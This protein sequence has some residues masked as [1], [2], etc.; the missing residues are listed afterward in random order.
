MKAKKFPVTQ[1]TISNKLGRPIDSI[2]RM[3]NLKSFYIQP[4]LCL[5]TFNDFFKSIPWEITSPLP[6]NSL[7]TVGIVLKVNLKGLRFF[8]EKESNNVPVNYFFNKDFET[9]TIH[10][11]IGSLA[12][13]FYKFIKNELNQEI[14]TIELEFSRMSIS[15]KNEFKS[16]SDSDYKNDSILILNRQ[17]ITGGESILK[18]RKDKI[19]EEIIYQRKLEAGD[20]VFVKNKKDH[21]KYIFHQFSPLELKDQNKKE[22]WIDFIQ[23]KIMD[24]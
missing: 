23:F 13:Q 22:G 16:Q 15:T 11:L 8:I 9:K 17:N 21:D 5:T 6:S 1:V 2:I 18:E 12:C 10:H 7:K 20:F 24:S 19:D 4:D 14:V 3:D